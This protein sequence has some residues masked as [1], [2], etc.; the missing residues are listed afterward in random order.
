MIHLFNREQ[1]PYTIGLSWYKGLWAVYENNLWKWSQELEG[2]EP[3]HIVESHAERK[4]IF[5]DNNLHPV[6]G[7]C[8]KTYGK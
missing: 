7:Y 4:K 3:E 1:C 6:W 5:I 8:I 2:I